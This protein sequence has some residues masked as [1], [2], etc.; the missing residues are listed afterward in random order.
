[1]KATS[2]GRN[3]SLHVCIYIYIFFLSCVY[4][5]FI[6]YLCIRRLNKHYSDSYSAPIRSSTLRISLNIIYF[7]HYGRIVKFAVLAAQLLPSHTSKLTYSVGC[8]N[9]FISVA[10]VH[11]R[12]PLVLY[13][14]IYP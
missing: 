13:V 8:T 5:T 11:K 4:I 12:V 10:C 14:Q 9:V 3:R 6:L 7:C 2:S 1:M